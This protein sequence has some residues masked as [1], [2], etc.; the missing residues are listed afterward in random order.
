VQKLITPQYYIILTYRLDGA[1]G[2]KAIIFYGSYRTSTIVK[3]IK[4]KTAQ[5]V[6]AAAMRYAKLNSLSIFEVYP[7]YSTYHELHKK[8]I[9]DKLLNEVRFELDYMSETDFA[10][11]NLIA[12]QIS[13]GESK[14]AFFKAYF[15]L[16]QA[17]QLATVNP[18]YECWMVHLSV[19]RTA[20][21]R[22][23]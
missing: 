14:R 16:K 17:I 2:S 12:L 23:N 3:S 10:A 15:D 7:S 11:T 9:D 19:N 20:G 8:V 18:S 13:K 21:E 5:S 6:L 22:D 1:Q 4:G